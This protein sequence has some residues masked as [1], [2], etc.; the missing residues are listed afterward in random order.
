MFNHGSNEAMAPGMIL[1]CHVNY[2]KW[3]RPHYYHWQ[4]DTWQL[5]ICQQL[6]EHHVQSHL[7]WGHGTWHNS[8]LSCQLFGMNYTTLLLPTAWHLPVE[9]IISGS[10]CWTSCS[11]MAQ[12]RSWHLRWFSSVMSIIWNDLD[13]IIITDSLTFASWK[14]YAWINL[15]NIMFNHGSND[16]MA[17]G[18]ILKCHVNYLEEFRQ[19]Y[20]HPQLDICQLQILCLDQAAEH[21]VQPWLKWGHGPW[22]DSE[23]SCW[24]FGMI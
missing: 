20:Y 5:G 18:M 4:L 19:H 23:V 2:L 9:N 7:E 15:L 22:D 17:F 13:H 6:A 8:E 1:N 14:Y 11:T 21:Y 3:F 10:I 12:M 24:L 16:S